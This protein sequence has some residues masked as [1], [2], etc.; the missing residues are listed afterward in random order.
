MLFS[1]AGQQTPAD[2]HE[3]TADHQRQSG[4]PMQTQP[5]HP[6]HEHHAQ[7][8]ADAAGNVNEGEHERHQQHEVVPRRIGLNAVGHEHRRAQQQKPPARKRDRFLKLMLHD[9]LGPDRHGQQK[10]SLG[11]T[12]QAAIQNDARRQNEHHHQR[13][14]EHV[15]NRLHGQ[16]VRA[17]MADRGPQKM[18]ALRKQHEQAGPKKQTQEDDQRNPQPRRGHGLL[19]LARQ[20]PRAHPPERDGFGLVRQR[21]GQLPRTFAF[22]RIEHLSP[23][24]HRVCV[25]TSGWRGPAWA[26]G[27]SAPLAAAVG[28]GGGSPA[29]DVAEGS[30]SRISP[31]VAVRLR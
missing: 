6:V 30:V 29:G 15:V 13:S 10:G 11:R 26:G 19:A 3:R 21:S 18:K 27:K 20:R 12:I 5:R 17:S 9:P 8:R 23:G 25:S 28:G 1:A 4:Q 7:D 31:G 16:R 22:G 14:E 24:N 2:E